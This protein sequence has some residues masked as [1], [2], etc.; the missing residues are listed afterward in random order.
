ML[1]YT[2]LNTDGV[3]RFSWCRVSQNRARITHPPHLSLTQEQARN[4]RARAWA[5]VFDCYANKKGGPETALDDAERR[6]NEIRAE[7]ILS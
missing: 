5:F 4:A 3:A 6:S 1:C 2:S 7:D